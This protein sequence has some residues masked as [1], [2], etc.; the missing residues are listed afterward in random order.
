MSMVKVYDDKHGVFTMDA[1][2]F[3]KRIELITSSVNYDR[4]A[5]RALQAALSEATENNYF[6]ADLSMIAAASLEC[7]FDDFTINYIMADSDDELWVTDVEHRVVHY[8]AND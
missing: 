2:K 7:S 5:H 8:V 6:D 1:D 3:T 4:K